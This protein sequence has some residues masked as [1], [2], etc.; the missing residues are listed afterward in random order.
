MKRTQPFLR[1]AQTIIAALGLAF[2]SSPPSALAASPTLRVSIQQSTNRTARITWGPPQATLQC[3]DRLTGNFTN[4]Q[5]ATVP[6]SVN[7]L[8]GPSAPFGP[9]PSN[10]SALGRASPQAV[11]LIALRTIDSILITT[12]PARA[13]A[14]LTSIT[15][16]NLLFVLFV[17]FVLFCRSFQFRL[18][19]R[20]EH[21]FQHEGLSPQE[22]T[23]IVAAWQ[24]KAISPD[25]MTELFRKGEVLPEGRT[26]QEDERMIQN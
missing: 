26:R 11:Q 10:H 12:W 23:A 6:Y 16:P 17:L 3:S 9:A 8:L 5:N 18:R 7:T 2:I 21:G 25:T 22:I 20:V 13:I 15:L 24:A 4:V 19:G 1:L 14:A